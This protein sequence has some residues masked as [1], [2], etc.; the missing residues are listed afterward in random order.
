MP[1]K[2]SNQKIKQILEL[3]KQEIDPQEIATTI[4]ISTVT[5]YKIL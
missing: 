5:V 4:G 1:V 3:D 2:I